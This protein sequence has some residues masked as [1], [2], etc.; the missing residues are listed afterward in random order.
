MAIS[1]TRHF[2]KGFLSGLLLGLLAGYGA[3]RLQRGMG[4]PCDCLTFDL[5]VGAFFGLIAGWC[6]GLQSLLKTTLFDLF[7]FLSRQ[8]PWLSDALAS[9]WLSR[10]RFFF[11]GL[12]GKMEGAPKWLMGRWILRRLGEAAP[13]HEAVE[14]VR[15]KWVKETPPTPQ[16]L[17]L[18]ALEAL[19]APVTA[20]FG[21]A[22][23]LLLLCA[24]LCWSIPFVFKGFP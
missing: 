20:A 7:R 16:D 15:E 10:L 4:L 12:T 11:E 3:F 18:G 2:A 13:F 24:L 19:W 6:Y 1:I 9:D 17:S 8:I 23:A 21:A 22:Y 5:W 14:R